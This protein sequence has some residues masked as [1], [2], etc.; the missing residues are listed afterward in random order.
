MAINPEREEILELLQK[1]RAGEGTPEEEARILAWFQS[2]DKEELADEAQY[3]A[4]ADEAAGGAM[5]ALFGARE[6]RIGGRFVFLRAAAV[7]L[8]V[9]GAALLGY[10]FLSGKA[11]DVTYREVL[12]QRGGRKQVTLPD[13]S[14]VTVNALSRLR[15][16]S[17][18]GKKDRRIYLEGEAFFDVQHD[19]NH[20]FIVHTAQLQTTVLGTSFDVK[21][22][23]ADKAIEIAVVSGKVKV[24]KVQGEKAESLYS[25]I[26]RNQLLA[27]NTE[28]GAAAV[29][30]EKCDLLAGWTNN[31]FYFENASIPQIAAA[32]ERQFDVHI[33]LKSSARAACRYT[34]QLKNENISHAMELLSELSGIT[35]EMKGKEIIINPINCW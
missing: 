33:T 18:F 4:A 28:T 16:P 23:A 10:R 20:P 1:F 21:A 34:L 11:E 15:I 31:S 17:D 8:L 5:T 27:Y 6:R 26:T 32:L 24:D 2:F 30:D 14:S 13:G 29:R 3:K 12:T 7:V 22:Y 35:Y 9:A 25:G 19:V